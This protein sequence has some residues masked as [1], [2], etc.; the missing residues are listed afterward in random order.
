MKKQRLNVV[1][2]ILA[3]HLVEG[4]PVTDAELGIRINLVTMAVGGGVPRVPIHLRV[5]AHKER[6]H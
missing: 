4:G 3:A 5:C 2:K 6:Q 1:Q